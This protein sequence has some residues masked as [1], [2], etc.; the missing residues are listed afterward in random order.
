MTLLL[1]NWAFVSRA[2]VRQRFSP[3][4]R[5]LLARHRL[6]LSRSGAPHTRK[7]TSAVHLRGGAKGWTT[8][9]IVKSGTLFVLSGLAEIGGGWLVW[10][11]VREG[12]NWTHGL[13]GALSLAA[14]GFIV[15]QQ[16]PAAGEAFGRLDAAYGGVF[17]AMSFAWG[18]LVE[19]VPLDAGDWVGGA[20]CLAGVVVIMG[21]P[22]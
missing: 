18:R 10:R 21:W 20:L 22:R 12:A 8:A 14:Y 15:T 4:R 19:G 6:D 2:S 16:P 11:Y 7:E 5:S 1:A 3:R 9:T 17:I 13:A